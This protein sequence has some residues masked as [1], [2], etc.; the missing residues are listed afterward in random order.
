MAPILSIK[1]LSVFREQKNILR[2]INWQIQPGE[3]WVILG[4]NGSGKTCLL[5][6]ITGY[7]TP[8]GGDITFLGEQYG[9]YDWRELRKSV[10]F[11]SSGIRQL[12]N[13]DETGLEVVASGL[14]AMFNSFE[15]WKPH[16]IKLAK[17]LLS[18]I[19]CSYL[20]DRA[21][22]VMSHGERQRVLIAR[23]LMA[24]ARILILDE[25]CTGLDPLARENFLQFLEAFPGKF[26]DVSLVLVTHHI[27]EIIPLFSHVLL[28]GNG[29]I[30]AQGEIKKTLNRSNLNK[31]FKADVSIALK[32]RRYQ[33]RISPKKDFIT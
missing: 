18:K 17:R 30:V 4:A 28:L 25:P 31:V 20:K 8:S 7:L 15:R 22:G 1:N 12:I 29:T 26:K 16:E 33:L 11:V 32:N 13:D 19:E 23:A 10:G 14:N 27:E 24:E 21:W 6:A 2:K 5:K 3:H 9:E